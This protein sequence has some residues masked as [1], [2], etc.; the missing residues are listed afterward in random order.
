M[1]Y[2]LLSVIKEMGGVFY[3]ACQCL[4]KTQRF[5]KVRKEENSSSAAVQFHFSSRLKSNSQASNH[6]FSHQ[7]LSIKPFT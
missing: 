7:T 6:M 5:V 4:V 2:A 3:P 1:Q